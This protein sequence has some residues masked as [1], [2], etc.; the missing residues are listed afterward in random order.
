[1][2][3]QQ[4][5]KIPKEALIALK[6]LEELAYRNGRVKLKFLKTYRMICYWKGVEYANYI[7]KRLVE[8]K[9]IQV[10]GEYVNLLRQDI[11]VD[12]SL[13]RILKELKE[14]LIRS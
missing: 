7:I 2:S 6:I 13:T 3:T 5:K 9:Y 8:G 4:S 1:M 11:K 12:K 14:L 10:N